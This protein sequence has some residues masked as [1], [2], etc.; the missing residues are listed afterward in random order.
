MASVAAT[1]LDEMNTPVRVRQHRLGH[2]PQGV[3]LR[4]YTH[5]PDDVDRAV[6]DR[7]DALFAEARGTDVARVAG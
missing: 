2:A 7:P 5:V 3:T 4:T 6:A 1:Y